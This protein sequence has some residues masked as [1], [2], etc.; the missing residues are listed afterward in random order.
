MS[1]RLDL[2]LVRRGLVPSRERA[3]EAV[4]AGMVL[5][6]GRPAT[7]SAQPVAETDELQVTG[8]P[9]GYVGRGGLKLEAA[10]D[11]FFID[12]QGQVCLDVGASTGGFTEC[13][14]RRGAALVY[15]LDVG[16]DQ[17]HP[18]LRGNERIVVMEETDIRSL[19]GLPTPPSLVTVDVSFISLRHVLPAVGRLAAPGATVVTLIKPQFEIGP[20]KV[21]RRGIVRDPRLLGAAIEGVVEEAIAL[22]WLP[23]RVIPSP[24][25]GTEGNQEYLTSFR[26]PAGSSAKA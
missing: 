5:V 18:S 7:R 16:R 22:G 25:K 12:P 8:D 4:K 10:L 3:Q 9:I 20:G 11:A 14:L 21:D 24:I 23:G 2:A 13:L 19:A 1:Q 15:A 6:N 17:L 26:L